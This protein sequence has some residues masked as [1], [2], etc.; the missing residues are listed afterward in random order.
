VGAPDF[1]KILVVDDDAA[2]CQF[3]SDGLSQEGFVVRVAG[4]AE[5]ALAAVSEGDIGAALV[6]ISMRQMNRLDLT[7]RILDQRPAL[8]FVV[9]TAFGSVES[10]TAAIR[11]GAYDCVTEILCSCTKWRSATFFAFPMRPVAARPPPR[12]FWAST[13]GPCTAS[14]SSLRRRSS[15]LSRPDC[16]R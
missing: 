15:H 4:S 14:W 10:A 2:F 9:S 12:R 8:P 5:L 16:R 7:R 13:D 6:D 11:A 3:V 1:R